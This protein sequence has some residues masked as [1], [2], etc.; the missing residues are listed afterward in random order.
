MYCYSKSFDVQGC[1]DTFDKM[2]KNNCQPTIC[3]YNILIDLFAQTK[4]DNGK[5]DGKNSNT[6][7]EINA[8]QAEFWLHK[9]VEDRVEL[10]VISFNSL[11]HA[12]SNKNDK[13]G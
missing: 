10:G 4:Y 3:S 7:L 5:N 1:L 9:A 2:Q 12:F 8:E 11:L 13:E 6:H